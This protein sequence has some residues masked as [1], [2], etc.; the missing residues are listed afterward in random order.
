VQQMKSRISALDA[1]LDLRGYFSRKQIDWLSRL[2][3]DASRERFLAYF[4]WQVSV[5]QGLGGFLTIDA[6][7]FDPQFAARLAA[8]VA[9]ACD[10]M[11]DQMTARARSDETRFAEAELTREEQ[12][13]RTARLALTR[14]QDAHGDLDPQRAAGQLGGIVGGLES[15]LAAARAQLA[16]TASSLNAASPIVQQMKSR[17]SALD[18]QLRA[19]K[20][21]LAG[22]GSG[23][24]YSSLLEQYSALQLEEEFAKNAYQSAQQ[25]LAVARA[26][27]ARQ[28]N[29][30]VDFAPPV[31]PDQPT[32]WFPMTY[33]A[34]V[35]VGSLLALGFGSLIV[36]AFRDHA[37]F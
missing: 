7:A 1:Q 17:I 28:E 16:D 31:E 4:R 3:P 32:L 18:A 10:E 24:P 9:R 27:A 5:S 37:G 34:T 20:A 33:T 11:I 15:D 26:D 8:A 2:P 36:G 29:Y 23:T 22:D 13:L 14:F 35:L 25:G 19:Q 30:L 21:R 12:R 6:Q